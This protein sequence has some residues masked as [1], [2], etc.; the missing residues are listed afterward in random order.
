[1][2][3]RNIIRINFARPFPTTRLGMSSQLKNST[4]R[5]MST[6]LQGNQMT[7]LQIL[8]FAEKKQIQHRPY[9]SF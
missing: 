7:K 1:M 3:Q 5:T 4:K 2:S 8:Q 9:L 6:S